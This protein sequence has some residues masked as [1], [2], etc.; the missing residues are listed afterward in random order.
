MQ[1]NFTALL[2]F[3]MFVL[4][5]LIVVGGV[6]KYFYGV[7]TKLRAE[8]LGRLDRIQGKIDPIA[9][10]VSRLEE[11]VNTQN[12]RVEKAENRLQHHEDQMVDFWRAPPWKE[13]CAGLDKRIDSLGR[14]MQ[15]IL[16]RQ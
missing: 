9:I 6:A 11:H 2:S 8:V 14:E 15:Q 13:F 5:L 3:G 16:A 1:L 4:T 12:G 10:S 7:V